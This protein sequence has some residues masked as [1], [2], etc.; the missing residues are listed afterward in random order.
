MYRIALILMILLLPLRGWMGDA[1]ATGMAAGQL[2]VLQTVQKKAASFPTAATSAT[3]ATENIA[4]HA[5]EKWAA[6]HNH[7]K[8]ADSHVLKDA[9]PVAEA[10]TV[11]DCGMQAMDVAGNAESSGMDC[12]T[13]ASCQACHTVVLSPMAQRAL[14][15]FNPAPLPEAAT[16]PYASADAALSQKPPIS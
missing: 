16:L 11:H 1:M 12:G 13:C 10:Q 8:N 7:L 5:H 9:Q 4:T 6:G 15:I 3:S 14:A 2:T